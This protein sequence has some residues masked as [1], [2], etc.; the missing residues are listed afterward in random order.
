[1]LIEERERR[2]RVF[3]R[4]LN[5]KAIPY[6]TLV[7][8]ESFDLTRGKPGDLVDIEV[9]EGGAVSLASLKYREPTQ[10]RLSALEDKHLKELLI[11]THRNSPLVVV[12][13]DVERVVGAPEASRR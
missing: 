4:A 13:V 6:D 5:L 10:S 11:V 9:R 2:P 7:R 1:M 8:H 3:D 12:V